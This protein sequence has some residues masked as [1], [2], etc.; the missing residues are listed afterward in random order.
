MPMPDTAMAQSGRPGCGELAAVITSF[1]QG[2]MVR[3][4]L[5]SL[6]RQTMLPARILVVDDG[7]TD[8][9][10]LEL[11]QA[12]PSMPDAPVPAAVFRQ[13][14]KGVSAARNAGIQH[15]STPFVLILD[16]DDKLEPDYLEQVVG[17]LKSSPEMVAASAWMHTFGVLE[18]EVRPIGGRLPEF[19]VRN[20][21]PATHVMRR[22]AWNA[23]GGY[24]ETMRSGFEDWD[25]FL[26][27]LETAPD[28][29]IGIVDK[30]LLDYRT[31]PA[32]SNVRSMSK[33]LALM[34]YLI[35]KH[36]RSYHQ[37]LT[38]A[39]LGLE[40]ISMGRLAGWESEIRAAA[41]Q[42]Q[43]H[44]PESSAFLALPSY[45]D[46]GMAAAVRIA[47]AHRA[48]KDDMN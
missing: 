7:S 42:G 13:A 16:G 4:A 15:T 12:I 36:S 9:A 20:C 14:N 23:C 48:A 37:Y 8:P 22:S 34:E 1:N 43:A 2:S 31:A 6:Y 44:S 25:F 35:Q 5:E 38:Q 19:L 28:A 17:L 3:D 33:R 46:G 47:T 26:G 24:D 21:C 30:P 27:L 18:A 29:W 41:A 45:G 39:L 10:T 40:A 11:L 32:S